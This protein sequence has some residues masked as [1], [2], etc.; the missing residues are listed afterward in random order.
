MPVP[1]AT[2]PPTTSI[3]THPSYDELAARFEKLAG[4]PPL[5]VATAA[6]PTNSSFAYS[7]PPESAAL[8]A[9]VAAFLSEASLL[10][11]VNVDLAYEGDRALSVPSTPL[12]DVA[13]AGPLSSRFVDYTS[14][15]LTSPTH[16][17][18]SSGS[19]AEDD[20]PEVA[21]LLDQVRAEVT[22]ENKHR[23][24]LGGGDPDPD[25]ILKDRIKGVMDFVPS[26]GPA[27]TPSKTGR[28]SAP[29][30]SPLGAPP[31]VPREKD[32]QDETDGWC[33]ICNDDA[34][35]TCE[36]EDCEDDN[37]C[38]R[39]FREAHRDGDLRKHVAKR[40]HHNKK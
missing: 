4:K 38:I 26:S 13:P 15:V 12:P 17:P 29:S 18:Q 31:P 1:H 32:F 27:S 30:A 28:S 24:R 33:C 10:N 23:V 11:D 35:V 40:L 8:D 36:H 25:D 34:T 6:V 5:A 20:D 21:A 2:Y 3:P 7:S 14:L 16:P 22:L 39:C 9:D 19:F 37:Y